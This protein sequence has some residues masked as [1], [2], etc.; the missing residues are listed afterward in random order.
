MILYIA[1]WL[2][3]SLAAYYLFSQALQ[4]ELVVVKHGRNSFR[5][6]QSNPWPRRTGRRFYMGDHLR[7]TAIGVVGLAGPLIKVVA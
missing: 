6:H 5:L 4:A 1:L 3:T 7:D 2:S